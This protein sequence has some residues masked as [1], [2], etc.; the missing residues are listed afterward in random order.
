[1]QDNNDT[2]NIVIRNPDRP[3]HHMTKYHHRI[4]TATSN[5]LNGVL[6]MRATTNDLTYIPHTDTSL[7]KA[8]T[9][10]A[11]A[12]ASYTRSLRS[13]NH[14]T[15][16]TQPFIRF[17][18]SQSAV[19]FVSPPNDSGIAPDAGQQRHT[20]RT[21]NTHINTNIHNKATTTQTF[22][23]PGLSSSLDDV[24]NS[25][26]TTHTYHIQIHRD[27]AAATITASAN[28]SYSHVH[29]AAQTIEPSLHNLSAG[30][31]LA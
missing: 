15:I 25:L 23:T 28:D 3:H 11:S 21:S 30:F 20:T 6:I 18:F 4:T 9:I 22:Q 8:T 2:F 1:M 14:R 13:S 26:A 10:T 19:K 7:D 16:A 17:P 12:N 5:H 31:H 29:P 24:C 27:Q